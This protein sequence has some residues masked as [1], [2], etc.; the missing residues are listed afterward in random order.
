MKPPPFDLADIRRYIK[1]RS[2]GVDLFQ[3]SMLLSLSYLARDIAFMSALAVL[4]SKIE[5]LP[6]WLQP[7]GWLAYWNLQGCIFV[8]LWIVAHECGHRAFSNSQTLN[9][10]VGHALHSFLLVPYHSWRITHAHHHSHTNCVEHDAVYIPNFY[11]SSEALEL[12]GDH[13]ALYEAFYMS[14]VG[15]LWNT[16]LVTILGWPMYLMYNAWGP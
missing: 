7:L 4:A 12:H 13:S 15:A 14:P 2:D 11:S 3:P 10:F 6:S 9:N 5:V 16:V 1:E 8:G